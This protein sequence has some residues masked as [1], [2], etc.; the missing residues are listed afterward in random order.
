[1]ALIKKFYCPIVLL[2][3]SLFS[4]QVIKI[5]K[6]TASGRFEGLTSDLRSRS[7]HVPS[8]SVIFRY[9]DILYQHTMMYT[10]EMWGYLTYIQLFV[11]I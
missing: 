3:T 10:I 7:D 6:V 5:H 4:L 1:M 11:I 2:T 9:L 8:L